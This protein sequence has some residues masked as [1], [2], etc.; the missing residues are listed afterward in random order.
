MGGNAVITLKT[1]REI[2]LMRDAGRIAAQALLAVGEKIRPG[3]TT[4][5]LDRVANQFIKSCGA[6]P[7][8]LGYNNFPASACVSVNSE[9]IHGLPSKKRV[10][11]EGDLVS[12]DLGAT[13]HG[14]IGDTAYTF[15]VGQLPQEAA[16]LRE[17]TWEA[18]LAGI[19]KALPGGKI[20]DIGAAVQDL[21]EARGCSVVRS[22]TGHGVGRAMHED[23]SV[24]NFGTA[25][26]GLKLRA[27][28]T[29]AIEP[30]VNAGRNHVTVLPDGWT[31]VTRDG[32]LSAH[33]EHTIA[34]TNN[35]P[36]ILTEA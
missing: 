31:V 18:L 23:P 5:E 4:W 33:M 29:I 6:E 28:M 34:I 12:V 1:G 26:K 13:Y 8:F 20:G 24:P 21:C 27:G 17:T 7:T 30:M 22:Y 35:G 36:V 32:S 16:A 14:Y 15:P 10:L 25:G 19:A 9:V 3:V 11:R 2:S